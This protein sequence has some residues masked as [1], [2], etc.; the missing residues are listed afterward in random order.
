MSKKS[1]EHLGLVH[2]RIRNAVFHY[3]Q[4]LQETVNLIQEVLDVLPGEWGLKT[5][6]RKIRIY[7]EGQ[8]T[9]GVIESVAELLES[10]GQECA[11]ATK[12]EEMIDGE[13]RVRF[14]GP[15]EIAISA[16]TR[17]TLS[18]Q[19]RKFNSSIRNLFINNP[20]LVSFELHV[21]DGAH[22][23]FGIDLCD[24]VCTNGAECD[25]QELLEELTGDGV[26][27]DLLMVDGRMFHREDFPA[28]KS[29]LRKERA[30]A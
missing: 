17:E 26:E 4:V 16:I 8:V 6:G 28:A 7:G 13:R 3:R 25:G 24:I 29:G 21:H 19:Y 27:I 1:D 22:E 11:M 2:Y 14:F 15:S 23:T 30:V 10:M 12:I 20:D 9:D 18:P 5:D